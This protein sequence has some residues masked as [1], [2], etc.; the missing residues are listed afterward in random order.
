M[1]DLLRD[2][3]KQTKK[4]RK[5]KVVV[6]SVGVYP[7]RKRTPVEDVAIYQ[8]DGTPTIKPAKF[9]ERAAR[10]N[11]DWNRLVGEAV[12]DFL[13][14]DE[15]ALDEAGRKIARDINDTVN[16]IDTGRL[17]HSMKHKID[18]SK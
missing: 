5:M 8:N 2:L 14:E 15:K 12:A 6:E 18:E 13:D 17:R 4:L 10:K 11:N 3:E 9:I 16:R 7:D 1:E